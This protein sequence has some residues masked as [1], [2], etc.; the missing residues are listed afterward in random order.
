VQLD[1]ADTRKIIDQ[2][3]RQAGWEVDSEKIKFNKGARQEKNRNRAIAEWPTESGL[4]DYVLFIGLT[5]VAVVEAK[6]KNIDVSGAL[7]QAK[8]YSRTFK[9]NSE[10]TLPKQNWGNDSGSNASC[11]W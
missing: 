4:A 11:S 9:P 8:R 3:L 5:P 1:E 6:R 7:Q 2:Q 10:T